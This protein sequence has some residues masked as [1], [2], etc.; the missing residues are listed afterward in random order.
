VA[1]AGDINGDGFDDIIIG[2]FRADSAGNTRADAGES[3]VVF[4]KAGGFGGSFSL[5]SVAAGTGGFVILGRQ[6]GDQSGGAVASAGDINGD[7]FDDLIV[8]AYRANDPSNGTL[9]VGVTTVILGKAT[10]F[11]PSIDLTS[12]GDGF[13]GFTIVGRSACGGAGT[14]VG[15]AG[16]FN[17]DGFADIVVGAPSANESFVVFGKLHGFG[18]RIDLANVAAG[19]GG[20]ILRGIDAYDLAGIS[21][22]SAGD[23]NGDGLDD[24]IIGAR[25]ADGEF[26]TA[27]YSGD[28][29]VVFGRTEVAGIVCTALRC[30]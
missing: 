23:I 29:Y 3:Y 24:L 21:V 17:G 9:R 1:S 28:S 30:R 16:D 5:A 25:H 22:S 14:S 13:D 2:A 27:P 6:A 15:S 4:G 18:A 8:G 7:G 20:F 12:F 10:G 19:T 11:E 26:N